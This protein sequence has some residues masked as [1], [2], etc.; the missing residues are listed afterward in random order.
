[1]YYRSCL[2]V[3]WS[4]RTFFVGV[5]SIGMEKQ[6]NDFDESIAYFTIRCT[7]G[8]KGIVLFE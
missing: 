4:E 5:T 2:F 3:S 1:M 6:M 8:L 7:V